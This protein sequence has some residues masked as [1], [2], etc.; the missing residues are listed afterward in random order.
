[1]SEEVNLRF[2]VL[3]SVND[4]ELLTVDVFLPE[5]VLNIDPNHRPL[6]DWYIESF[7]EEELRD[8][9]PDNLELCEDPILFEAMGKYSV[10]AWQDYFGEWDQTSDFAIISW[11]VAF[12]EDY[13]WLT[14]DEEDLDELR[15]E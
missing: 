3:V 11:A 15:Q 5:L 13:P 4:I 14:G 10:D 12:P 1:M 8:L 9:L 7:Q 2:M 6:T